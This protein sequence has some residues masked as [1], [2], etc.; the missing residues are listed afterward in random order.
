MLYSLPNFMIREEAHYRAITKNQELGDAFSNWHRSNPG[1]TVKAVFYIE[2][3]HKRLMLR[4]EG[5]T[6]EQREE[7]N[8][9]INRYYLPIVLKPDEIL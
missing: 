4:V 2:D 5:G 1:H 3:K 7:V 9:L 8:A 6:L